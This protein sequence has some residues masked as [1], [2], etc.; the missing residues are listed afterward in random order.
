MFQPTGGMDRIAMGFL[1]L[2][3]IARSAVEVAGA[4][5]IETSFPGFVTLMNG[6]GAGI[7]AVDD[8]A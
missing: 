5:A 7:S 3:G 6:L 4:E 1:V 8:A 2:G